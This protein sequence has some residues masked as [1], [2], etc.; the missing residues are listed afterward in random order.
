MKQPSLSEPDAVGRSGVEDVVP[1][2]DKKKVPAP[3]AS[4]CTTTI[5]ADDAAI[6]RAD[7]F[8]IFH[9]DL[10]AEKLLK[11]AR[12]FDVEHPELEEEKKKK[13]LDRFSQTPN[14]TTVTNGAGPVSKP[15]T[16]GMSDDE[17]RAQRAKRFASAPTAPP[18][19]SAA[20]TTKDSALT[21][22]EEMKNKRLERFGTSALSDE[23][24]KARRAARFA[25]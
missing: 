4:A 9:P 16:S 18:E 20:A 14:G 2:E 25:A 13:R 24:K 8:K 15:R 22:E 21:A 1:E 11:R 6:K 12:R 23:Q 19:T 5:A 3:V 7:R 17:K 10:E